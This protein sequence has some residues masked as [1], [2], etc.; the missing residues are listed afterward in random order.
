MVVC[1]LRAAPSLAGPGGTTLRTNDEQ[2]QTE[3]KRKRKR[4][5]KRK[6]KSVKDRKKKRKEKK[7][8][9]KTDEWTDRRRRVGGS[10][11]GPACVHH[12]AF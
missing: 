3:E 12:P 4:K 2:E 8:Y 6:K 7:N 9:K 10:P 5:R 1:V 11:P